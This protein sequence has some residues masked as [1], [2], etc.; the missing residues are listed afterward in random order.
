MKKLVIAALSLS[1]LPLM[2]CAAKRPVTTV[3]A[4]VPLSCVKEPIRM[5]GCNEDLTK[6]KKFYVTYVKACA[7]V[8]LRPK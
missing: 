5:T 2:G 3:D 8:D 6:C 1:M 7:I 4:T